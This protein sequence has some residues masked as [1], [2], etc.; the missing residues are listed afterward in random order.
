MTK[1]SFQNLKSDEA[2]RHP[3]I[4]DEMAC[5]GDRQLHGSASRIKDKVMLASMDILL[6]VFS[7]W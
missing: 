7:K 1:S 4:A 6:N 5:I 2:L 3:M